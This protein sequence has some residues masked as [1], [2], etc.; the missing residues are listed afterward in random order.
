M[1]GRMSSILTETA[2]ETRKSKETEF[3]DQEKEQ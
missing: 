3:V 1:R 2:T